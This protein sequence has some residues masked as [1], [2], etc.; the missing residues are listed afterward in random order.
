MEATPRM[1]RSAKDGARSSL[2]YGG[3]GD[4]THPSHQGV[5][6]RHGTEDRQVT[7]GGLV[8]SGWRHRHES[9]GKEHWDEGWRCAFIPFRQASQSSKAFYKDQPK[10]MLKRCEKSEDRKVLEAANNK[11]AVITRSGVALEHSKGV[12]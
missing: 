11:S 5:C 10:G 7:H 2:H 6:G 4:L 8:S 12:L 9:V 3:E 1:N